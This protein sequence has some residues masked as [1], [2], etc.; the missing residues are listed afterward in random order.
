MHIHIHEIWQFV[1]KDHYLYSFEYTFN[2][3]VMKILWCLKVYSFSVYFCLVLNCR[4][5]GQVFLNEFRLKLLAVN[6]IVL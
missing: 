5:C 2:R 3:S 1:L 6:L 4:V